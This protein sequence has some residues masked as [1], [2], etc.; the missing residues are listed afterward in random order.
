MAL[1][2]R[3][4][5]FHDYPPQGAGAAEVFERGLGLVPDAVFL[6]H[7]GRASRAR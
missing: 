3:V 1:S 7:A 6:P 4:L 2:S 5:L